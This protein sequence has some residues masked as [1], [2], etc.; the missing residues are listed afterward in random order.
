MTIL[1]KIQEIFRDYFDDDALVLTLETSPDDVEEWDSLA[2]VNL[3]M[4]CESA[5]GVKFNFG[6]ISQIKKIGDIAEIV[7]RKLHS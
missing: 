3:I 5:F 6:D 4:A 7:E 1:E 2:Q